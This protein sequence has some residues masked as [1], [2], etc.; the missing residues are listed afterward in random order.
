[1]NNQFQPNYL[2][3]S[4]QENSKHEYLIFSSLT[5]KQN[6]EI[7]VIYLTFCLNVKTIMF[8]FSCVCLFSSSLPISCLVSFGATN[9]QKLIKKTGDAQ[10]HRSEIMSCQLNICYVLFITR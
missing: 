2:F 8:F 4:K 6:M 1:M 9:Y 7:K 5:K 3:L 10:L